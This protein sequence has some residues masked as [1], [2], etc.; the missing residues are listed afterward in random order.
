[1]TLLN[2]QA[3]LYVADPQ[4]KLLLSILSSTN[5]SLP[6]ET[7]P[8]FLRLLYIW[9]RKSS[10]PSPVLI[11]SAVKVLSDLLSTQFDSNKNS[12]FF[13]EVVVLLGAFSFA[14]SA[15]E[16]SKT[17]CLELLCGLL[18]DEYRLIGSSKQYVPIVLAGIGYALSSAG[19]VYFVRILDPLFGIW[20]REDGPCGSVSNGLMILHLIEWVLSSFINSN[21]LDRVD[22]FTKE[23]LETSNPHHASFATVMAAGGALRVSNTFLSNA[24]RQLRISAEEKIETVARGLIPE[25]GGLSKSGNNPEKSLLLKSISLALARSGSVSFRAP[26]LICLA[27]ALLTE[28]FPLEALFEKV[29]NLQHG[30]LSQL[31]INEVKEHLDSASFKEAGAMTGVFCNQYV[32][33]DENSQN[34]V[35]NLIWGYCQ[36]AYLGHRQ[37]ALMLRGR[38]DELLGDL[39]K[40]AESAFLMVVVF[41]LVV[42]KQKL[43]SKLSSAM[44]MEISVKILV[45]LSCMEYFR[46][47]RLP[48]YMDTIRAVVIAVQENQSACVLFVESMPPYSDLTNQPGSSSSQITEHTWWKDEV[49]T[50]RILFYLRVI[51]T[52]IECLP[53]PEF[54]KVVAP[55]MFLYM[56]HPNG[57]VARASHSMFVAFISSGKD[58]DEDERVLLKEQLVFYYIQRSLEG[59]PQI[60]PFEGI[61]SGVAALVRYLPAGSP[62]IFYTVHCLV[63]KAH[64]LCREVMTQESDSWQ[65]ELE[66]RKKLTDLLLRLLSIVDIQVLPSLMKQLAQLVAVL[67]REGQNMILNDLYAQVAE[68]DDVTRKPALVSWLQS[69]SYI[70][71]QA[72]SSSTTSKQFVLLVGF[73]LCRDG[74]RRRF[75]VAHSAVVELVSVPARNKSWPKNLV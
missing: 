49:Q 34:R 36:D 26:L 5:I 23:V 60:T 21:S 37:V 58:S 25:R 46:R 12:S 7:Y 6:L 32:S 64:D 74:W 28:I 72:N 2:S 42:T 9:I 70:C 24:P 53:V 66:P 47:I 75:V 19:N 41:A 55:I 39:E 18:E 44:Q 56:G 38:D 52:C 50:S 35:E 1:M 51:P 30:N 59:Y 20:T 33:A 3:S 73:I 68:S 62:S 8:L 31:G 29:L 27:S 54:R 16:K 22:V 11:D 67:P 14:S 13:S 63:E 4:A 61:A 71:S 15:L 17:L 69:L 57:K 45:S 48:E 10:K 65:D 40:I 43:D